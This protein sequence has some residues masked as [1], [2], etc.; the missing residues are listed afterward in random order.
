MRRIYGTTP[1]KVMDI[2]FANVALRDVPEPGDLVLRYVQ[3]V[4]P[5]D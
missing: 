5:K 1:D 4:Q 3:R 2:F